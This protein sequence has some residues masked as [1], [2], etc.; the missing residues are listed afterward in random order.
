MQTKSLRWIAYPAVRII[1]N[2]PP[3]A[4][5]REET[6]H[7]INRLRKAGCNLITAASSGSTEPYARSFTLNTRER[8]IWRRSIKGWPKTSTNT[9]TFARTGR[10]L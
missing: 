7:A 3:V 10:W 4:V 1:L 5:G 2:F 9:I 8:S 6:I